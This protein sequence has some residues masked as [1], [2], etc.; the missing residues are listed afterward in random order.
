VTTI[1]LLQ[2]NYHLG[3]SYRLRIRSIKRARTNTFTAVIPGHIPPSLRSSDYIAT[4]MTHFF[5]EGIVGATLVKH[6]PWGVLAGIWKKLQ[7]TEIQRTG[8]RQIDQRSLT[9]NNARCE[10]SSK[11]SKDKPRPPGALKRPMKISGATPDVPDN[12]SSR[13]VRPQGQ[14]ASNYGF[15]LMMNTTKILKRC[16]GWPRSGA[17]VLMP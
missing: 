12:V 2:S 4:A 5:S 14:R 11:R 9:M 17:G 13:S 10:G 16:S 8:T 6:L 3:S 7:L 1:K 15:L